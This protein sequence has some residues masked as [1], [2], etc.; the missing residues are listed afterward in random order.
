MNTVRLRMA[1]VIEK[2]PVH[3]PKSPFNGGLFARFA[4][5]MTHSPLGK[6]RYLAGVPLGKRRYLTGVRL[7][8][9]GQ[10][11]CVLPFPGGI[12]RCEGFDDPIAAAD[13]CGK[14]FDGAD[15]SSL[16]EG[17][18]DEARFACRRTR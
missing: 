11:L 15:V 17:D 12:S 10:G 5:R 6:R 7:V 4:L 16:R 13:G 2:S 14:G 1:K 9:G 8:R 3:P 18:A